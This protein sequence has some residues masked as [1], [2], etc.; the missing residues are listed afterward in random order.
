MWNQPI[1]LFQQIFIWILLFPPCIFLT[2]PAKMPNFYFVCKI[3][4]MFCYFEF[5]CALLAFCFSNVRWPRPN[6]MDSNGIRLSIFMVYG[7]NWRKNDSL[8]IKLMIYYFNFEWIQMV[9]VDTSP[10]LFKL[11]LYIYFR[12]NIFCSFLSFGLEMSRVKYV[13][14][15]LDKNLLSSKHCSSSTRTLFEDQVQV[16]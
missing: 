8:R 1:W 7:Q 15:R 10:T 5:S 13:W 14:A 2:R 6:K 3:S 16:V 4:T 12:Q 9:V 11:N